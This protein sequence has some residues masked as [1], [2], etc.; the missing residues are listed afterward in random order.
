MQEAALK[1]IGLW[2]PIGRD[3]TDDVFGHRNRLHVHEALLDKGCL[4]C[5]VVLQ[6]SFLFSNKKETLTLLFSPSMSSVISET[7]LAIVRPT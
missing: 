2:Y 6:E 5:L 4:E 7:S 1:K 3:L